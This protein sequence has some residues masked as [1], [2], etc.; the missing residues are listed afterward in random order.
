MSQ[1]SLI[2]TQQ[3]VIRGGRV[4]PVFIWLVVD[5]RTSWLG[6][7]TWGQRMFRALGPVLWTPVRATENR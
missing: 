3:T 1:R 6:P 5:L 4:G 7:C 2:K